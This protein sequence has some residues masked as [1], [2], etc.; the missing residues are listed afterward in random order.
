M[1]KVAGTFD[2]HQ[3]T[4][5]Q[6]SDNVFVLRDAPSLGGLGPGTNSVSSALLFTIE[7]WKVCGSDSY[8][9]ADY[10]F[11]FGW[12]GHFVAQP[13]DGFP[14]GLRYQPWIYSP[15]SF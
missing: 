14:P 2:C 1:L 13:T 15:G 9:I 12:S 6:F 11:G 5:A 3:S 7:A 8:L 10:R 4:P